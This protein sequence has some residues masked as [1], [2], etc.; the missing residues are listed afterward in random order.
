MDEPVQRSQPLAGF[1]GGTEWMILSSDLNEAGADQ[2]E[3]LHE[4]RA[5]VAYAT[6]HN[7]LSLLLVSWLRSA[8]GLLA[9]A[10]AAWSLITHVAPLILGRSTSPF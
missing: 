5:K 4:G 9:A 7:A 1:S 10:L 2:A 8:F 3:A 6:Q